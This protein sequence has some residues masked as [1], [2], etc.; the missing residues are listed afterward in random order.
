MKFYI[1]LLLISLIFKL[2]SQSCIQNSKGLL[3]Y[4]SKNVKG[5]SKFSDLKIYDYLFFKDI[6]SINIK[7]SF[8]VD[9]LLKTDSY[10]LVKKKKKYIENLLDINIEQNFSFYDSLSFSKEIITV[11]GYH[12][13]QRTVDLFYETIYFSDDEYRNYIK[14]SNS[15]S[16]IHNKNKRYECFLV[17]GGFIIN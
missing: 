14:I 7:N 11:D 10:I 1:I 2:R 16:F 13:R 9:S 12:L 6:K 15:G 8:N 17:L 3:V 4:I 5:E